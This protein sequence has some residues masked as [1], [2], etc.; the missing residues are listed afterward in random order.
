MEERDENRF[1]VED[2]LLAAAGRLDKAHAE[3]PATLRGDQVDVF[4]DFSEYLMDVATRPGGELPF[5][6]I[7]QPPRTGKT[8][9]AA[10]IV[11][12]TKLNAVYLVP[13]RI[14]IGQ[15]KE[16]FRKW[17]P[18]LDVGTYYGEE[19]NLVASGVNITTYQMANAAW[20]KD[21]L[22][23]EFKQAALVF[24]DEAH[25]CMTALRQD[26]LNRA[27][28][29]KVVRLALTATPD[30]SE[31][32]TLD[33]YFPELIHEITFLEAMELGL[34]APFRFWLAEV[35][36]DGSKVKI[37]NGDYV[38]SE[39]A[40]V[41][42]EAPFFKAVEVFRYLPENRG[43]PCLICCT[44]RSQAIALRNYLH[45]HRPEKTPPPK[46]LLGTTPRS[47]REKVLAKFEKGTYDTLINVGVLIQGWNS[48]RC[49]L[50]LDL[51]P[52]LSRVRCGQKYSRVLT[53]YGNQEARIYCFI[54]R[55]LPVWPVL[56]TEVFSGAL[57]GAYL[58][59]DLVGP[60]TG[61]GQE[62]T[63]QPDRLRKSPIE[64]VELVQRIIHT[65]SFEPPK[66]DPKDE[67]GIRQVLEACA[68]FD[69][70][71]PPK[72]S[73]FRWLMFDHELFRGRGLQ[74]LRHLGL[75]RSSTRDMG[76]AA[77][78]RRVC[79]EGEAYRLL[80]RDRW[81]GR[82]GAEEE[83]SDDSERSFFLSALNS[84]SSPDGKPDPRF[85]EAWRAMTGIE[86]LPSPDKQVFALHER[87]AIEEA[88]K[89]LLPRDERIIRLRFGLDKDHLDGMTLKE[90]GE[91]YE[92]GQQTI[93]HIEHR[94]LRQ[95]RH[96]RHKCLLDGEIHFFVHD[97]FFA[98]DKE[99]P[100]DEQPRRTI[101]S[102]EKQIAAYG[103]EKYHELV[104]N[105]YGFNHLIDHINAVAHQYSLPSWDQLK[106]ITPEMRHRTLYE[107]ETRRRRVGTSGSMCRESLQRAHSEHDWYLSSLKTLWNV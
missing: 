21:G 70:A 6:R 23:R 31:E 100:V 89:T 87:E 16:E 32:R 37:F 71:K 91:G 42:T 67:A 50:L 9:I 4:Q 33:R 34:L 8:V 65:S 105:V 40:N 76:Y 93:L 51:A 27:F 45:T 56:P 19:K 66:L 99:M 81:Y 18:D 88:L 59:G 49:K 36:A 103:P 15:A 25:Q 54:P 95:L 48:P 62:S 96:P 90:I 60:K 14:L 11:G 7:I 69:P 102:L 80:L 55:C 38:E 22:P 17:L 63:P 94:A 35:D 39:I 68:G 79:P 61:T 53:S 92:C 44:T 64:E 72:Y 83:S 74:L 58:A 97:K 98:Q 106:R 13:S 101:P 24:A 104:K 20:K 3:V 43:L 41:M 30:Y 46:L 75:R 73:V 107:V 12:A 86:D 85:V 1:E 2:A 47:E 82:Y 77:L 52:S 28:A 29:P 26:L 78:L 10:H 5:A 84:G 57:Q